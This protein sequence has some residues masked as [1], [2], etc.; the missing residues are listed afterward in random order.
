MGQF[1]S[2]L[3]QLFS[4]SSSL[5][6]LEAP[7]HAFIRWQSCGK[8]HPAELLLTFTCGLFSLCSSPRYFVLLHLQLHSSFLLQHLICHES[9]PVH[10]PH[11]YCH[12]YL[13]KW[14]IGI[15]T[16]K[17]MLFCFSPK[18]EV[19][20]LR[21]VQQL[22]L[23]FQYFI[24]FEMTHI[25]IL[26]LTRFSFKVPESG[27]NITKFVTTLISL[28]ANSK[29]LGS[30]ALVLID[31]F[32]SWFGLYLPASLWSITFDWIPVIV[33]FLLLVAKYFYSW[34]IYIYICHT[35]WHVGS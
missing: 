22:K 10:F 19:D 12:F 5:F 27:D 29:I 33:N 24:L 13:Q 25:V 11:R 30:C 17:L 21:P 1:W 14:N 9:H 35:P 16:D 20:E 3:L 8:S 18:A 34:Q 28:F 15:T 31:W 23:K 2:F 32:L 7:S 4:L 6:S 26:I